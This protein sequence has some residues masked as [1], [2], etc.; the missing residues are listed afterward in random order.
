[1][2]PFVNRLF[3]PVV[4][5]EHSL[6]LYHHTMTNDVHSLARDAVATYMFPFDSGMHLE[7]DSEINQRKRERERDKP[8]VRKN[9]V[10]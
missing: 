4:F 5:D 10:K 9:S 7:R 2:V 1:M 8:K 6:L 3:E